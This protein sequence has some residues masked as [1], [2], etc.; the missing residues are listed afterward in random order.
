M[1]HHEIRLNLAN[2]QTCAL[3]FILEPW[4]REYVL[5]PHDRFVLVFRSDEPVSEPEVILGDGEI[6]VWGSSGD[7]TVFKNGEELTEYVHEDMPLT[8]ENAS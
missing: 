7:V 1:K 3:K 8:S 6:E 4:G 5:R 2:S